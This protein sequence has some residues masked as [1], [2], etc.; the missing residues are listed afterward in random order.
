MAAVSTQTFVA[1]SMVALCVHRFNWRLSG[2]LIG[3]FIAY[4]ATLLALSALLVHTQGSAL[5]ISLLLATGGVLT[6]VACG[7]LPL[8]RMMRFRWK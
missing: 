1:V 8:K 5:V 2:A 7:L 4:G 6:A 3:P